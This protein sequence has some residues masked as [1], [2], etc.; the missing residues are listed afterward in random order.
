[1]DIFKIKSIHDIFDLHIQ[2]KPKSNDLQR[3]PEWYEQRR[4]KFTGSEIHKLMGT[5]N[6]MEWGRP[7]KLID[8]NETAKKYVFSRAK[9]R[10]RKKVI[11]KRMGRPANYG[12]EVESVILEMLK[13]EYPK[14]KFEE[15]GFIEFLKGIAGASCDGLVNYKMGLEMKG[16]VDWD[17]QYTRH[18]KPFDQKHSDFW[19]IQSGMLALN[20]NKF[21]YVLAEPPEDMYEPEIFDLSIK[22]VDASPIHQKAII[23][24]C[25]I[26]NEAINLYLSG[27]NFHEAI[28]QSCSNYEFN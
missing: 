19:Q 20:V 7:E 13:K 28:R 18:E 16:P 21:M 26:G 27:M 2:S 14:Y 23:Q 5:S 11:K 1:M 4:G 22:I 8:F 10:Q 17:T 9:E 24:R 6:K 15:V 12:K 25:E 3:T